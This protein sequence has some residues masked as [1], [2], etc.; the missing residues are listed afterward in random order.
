MFLEKTSLNMWWQRHVLSLVAHGQF[1]FPHGSE[2]SSSLPV[3]T[4]S[5]PIAVNWVLPPGSDHHEQ[6][7]VCLCVSLCVCVC[8]GA[9]LSL[10]FQAVAGLLADARSLADI[11]RE[12]ASNFR[13][14]YGYDIPLKVRDQCSS[15]GFWLLFLTGE[16]CFIPYF[17]KSGFPLFYFSFS[18]TASCRQSGHVCACLHPVQRCQA[19]WVQVSL[20]DKLCS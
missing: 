4:M 7:G 16:L 18:H 8:A 3:N 1:E 9:T 13:S 14:N 2:L 12:E 11:A 20:A 6:P 5:W 10:S 15:Q 17:C 19:F